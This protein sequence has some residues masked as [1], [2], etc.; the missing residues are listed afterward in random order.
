MWATGGTPST[1]VSI[2]NDPEYRFQW[3]MS[4]VGAPEAWKTLN[5]SSSALNKT[6]VTV[7][8]V[9]SG[10]DA[11]H[12]DIAAKLHPEI[13]YNAISKN[14]NVSDEL[15]HG[16]HVAGIVAAIVNND[17]AVVGVA[18]DHVQ[19]LSCKFL[20][21]QG[22]GYAS[23]AVACIE[24][25]L[26]NGADVITNSWSGSDDNPALRD[27]IQDAED[28]GMI[29]SYA[30]AIHVPFSQFPFIWPYLQMFYLSW[31]PVTQGQI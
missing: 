6:V 12:P 24:Y 29:F 11:A 1:N 21:G 9:D 7:C 13:G 8:V 30:R 14:S 18:S 20:S 28:K 22:Y 15:K 27:A 23:D 26:D 25:C 19:V 31:Q 17:M 16:T 4:R 10:I 2:P 5:E 3:G